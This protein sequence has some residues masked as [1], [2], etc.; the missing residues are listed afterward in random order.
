MSQIDTAIV[1]AQMSYTWVSL[2]RIRRF[3]AEKKCSKHV[4]L[5]FLYECFEWVW[6]SPALLFSVPITDSCAYVVVL[7]IFEYL[8]TFSSEVQLFWAGEVTGAS[9]LFYVNRYMLLVYTLFGLFQLL[10]VIHT[11]S[12]SLRMFALFNYNSWNLQ[13]YVWV[14]KGATILYWPQVTILTGAARTSMQTIL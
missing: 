2:L 7:V 3:P 8:V 4:L 12:V 13:V 1:I 14:F 10:P 9:V 6:L 11:M 5:P